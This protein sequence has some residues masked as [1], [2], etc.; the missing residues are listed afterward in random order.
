MSPKMCPVNHSLYFC[1]LSHI[2][3]IMMTEHYIKLLEERD[4]KPTSIRILVLKAMS[5]FSSAFS[6]SDLEARLDSVDKS[7]ISRTIR[8]FHE[9]QL[10]HSFDDGSGSAKYSICNRDCACSINDMH[11]HF[12]CNYCKKAFCLENVSVPDIKLP[13][14]M[15]VE[16]IN[17][18]IKGFCGRCN[19]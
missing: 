6:L 7:T 11:A 3:R 16:S 14:E 15:E 13:K 18:V 4:I 10:I 12:Y 17:L 9:H 2:N 8:L 19:K 1:D 5:Q